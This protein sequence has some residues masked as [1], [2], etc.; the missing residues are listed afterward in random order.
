[1]LTVI[2]IFIPCSV[3]VLPLANIDWSSLLDFGL[4]LVTVPML[5][6]KSLPRPETEYGFSSDQ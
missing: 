1:M 3:Q 6:A 2:V 4:D 5:L